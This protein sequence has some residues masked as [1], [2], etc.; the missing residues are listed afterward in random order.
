MLS[1][2][3]PASKNVRLS[4]FGLREDQVLHREALLVPGLT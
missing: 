1:D 4:A 3:H 2:Y